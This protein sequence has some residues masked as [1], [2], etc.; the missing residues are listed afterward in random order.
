MRLLV[1]FETDPAGRPVG[2]VTADHD[3]AE[4]FADWLDLLRLL[5]MWIVAAHPPRTTE[6]A[7]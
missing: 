3:A 2:T 7:L 5:D 6:G 1:E 4:P